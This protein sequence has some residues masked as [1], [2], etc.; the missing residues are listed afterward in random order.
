MQHQL[1]KQVV[2]GLF[3]L[4]SST[5]GQKLSENI[6]YSFGGGVALVSENDN[7][8]GANGYNIF[9]DVLLPKQPSFKF[10]LGKYSSKTKV[11]VLSAGD[12]SMQWVEGSIIFSHSVS[13]LQPYIGSGVG[14]YLF[15]H[16]LSEDLK[17]ALLE[18]GL[19]AEEN[20]QN[21]VGYNIQ[22]GLN[23]NLSQDLEFS[24]DVKYVFIQP[25]LAVKVTSIYSYDTFTDS[26][27]LKMNTIL[28]DVGVRLK[29]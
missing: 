6:K 5:F 22:G 16:N 26:N 1:T 21:K 19:R 25:K 2:I 27:D 8:A 10:A 15:T 11:D 18:Q 3:I 14:Y 7:V 17:S 20:I 28:I 29:M 12:F 13:K 9:L 23:I 4:L 24:A